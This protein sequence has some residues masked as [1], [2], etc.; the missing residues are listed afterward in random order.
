MPQ[1]Y[2][3]FNLTLTEDNGHYWVWASAGTISSQKKQEFTLPFSWEELEKFI[4]HASRSLDV[5]EFS[6]EDVV[7]EKELGNYLYEKLFADEILRLF[8]S[9]QATAESQE[10]GVRISIKFFDAPMLIRIPWELLVDKIKNMPFVLTEKTPIVRKLNMGSPPKLK[11][12][13][14]VLRVLVMISN[15]CNTQKLDVEKEWDKIKKATQT[16]QDGGRIVLHR[17]KPSLPE[18]SIPRQSRGL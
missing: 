3:D 9:L 8:T 17:V 11:Q 7:N 1:I 4:V 10:M 5:G 6:S 13:K 15:P 12:T 2:L 14:G 18:V 16:L